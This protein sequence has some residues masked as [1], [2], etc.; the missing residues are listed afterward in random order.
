MP[1]MLPQ[2]RLSL[3]LAVL[4]GATLG[5]TCNGDDPVFPGAGDKL[6][7]GTWGGVNA[8][9]IVND[10]IAHIHIACTL[11]NFPMPVTVDAAGRFTVA[12]TYVLRA[13]PVHIGP[14]LP[15]QFRGQIARSR[16]TLS[17]TVNDTVERKTVNLGPVTVTLGREPQMGPCPICRAEMLGQ[18]SE[19]KGQSGR[20]N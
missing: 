12:G 3:L 13:Y 14:D 17:I 16:L 9:V 5:A 1:R 4:A 18:R 6:T 15:A 7:T 8:G 10:T 11:G 20:V 2:L 19:V